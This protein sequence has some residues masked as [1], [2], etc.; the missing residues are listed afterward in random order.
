VLRAVDA[1]YSV[2]S[3]ERFCRFIKSMLKTYTRLRTDATNGGSSVIE[4]S[5]FDLMLICRGDRWVNLSI[6]VFDHPF[7]GQSFL[8]CLIFVIC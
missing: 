3:D 5:V 6:F 7:D 1:V 4:S 2:N 8:S